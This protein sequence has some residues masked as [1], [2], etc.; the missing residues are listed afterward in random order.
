[1]ATSTVL[2]DTLQIHGDPDSDAADPVAIIGQ[3]FVVAR[4]ISIYFAEI[5]C[6]CPAGVVFTCDSTDDRFDGVAIRRNDSGS[7]AGSDLPNVI[8]VFD[9]KW[10]GMSIASQDVSDV[11]RTPMTL[12]AASRDGPAPGDAVDSMLGAALLKGF[13]DGQACQGEPVLAPSACYPRDACADASAARGACS[14]TRGSHWLKVLALRSAL[15]TFVVNACASFRHP[16]IPVGLRGFPRGISRVVQRPE[17]GQSRTGL[18]LAMDGAG[19]KL[20]TVQADIM[21]RIQAHGQGGPPPAGPPQAAPQAP[22]RAAPQQEAASGGPEDPFANYSIGNLCEQVRTPEQQR[23][24]VKLLEDRQ[25]VLASQQAKLEQFVLMLRSKQPTAKRKS[26]ANAAAEE[27]EP[28]K[29]QAN[30]CKLFIMGGCPRG[31]G[32][33]DIHAHTQEEAEAMQAERDKAAEQVVAAMQ[34]QEAAMVAAAAAAAQSTESGWSNDDGGWS[35]NGDWSS[36]GNGG[37]W[38]DSGP[39]KGKGKAKGK[40]KGKDACGKKGGKGKSSSSQDWSGG[41]GSGPSTPV[42]PGP[43]GSPKGKGAG[44]AQGWGADAAGAD[45]WGGGAGAPEDYGGIDMA[46]MQQAAAAAAMQLQATMMGGKGK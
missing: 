23:Q 46:A 17:L 25:R 7:A 42:A 6:W 32:C 35:G 37:G 16:E 12:D 15:D 28:A 11:N 4:R 19:G 18:Q 45:G 3:P 26:E 8:R 22:P 20:S 10:Y 44:G 31:D 9:S 14:P 33:P 13:L 39:D 5:D 40:G 24:F 36:W 30:L 29:R 27:A 41:W 21:A 1:M 43:K 34:A 38:W 2:I